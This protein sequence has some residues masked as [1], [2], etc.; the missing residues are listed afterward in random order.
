MAD[1]HDRVLIHELVGL[2]GHLMDEGRFDRLG[3]LFTD[4]VVYDVSALG[5]GELRGAAAIAEAGRT[6][7][8]RNPVGHH[9][10]N[11]VVTELGDDEASVVSK[12]IG[13]MADGTAGSVV[14]EDRVRR[15][16]AGWRIARRRV[17]PRR[18]PLRPSAGG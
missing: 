3:E 13:I 16:S 4:D 15:T 1:A 18:R 17:L 5:G 8:D 14:Y 2:H 9:V 11:I 10:T 12:G 6:L 7:G